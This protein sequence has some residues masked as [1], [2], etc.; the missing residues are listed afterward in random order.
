M[1]IRNKT[2]NEKREL[3]LNQST[4]NTN[5]CTHADDFVKAYANFTRNKEKN[6]VTVSVNQKTTK[7]LRDSGASV[8]CISKPFFEKAFLDNKPSINPC[9]IRSID[10][11]GGTHHASC[12]YMS[13][14]QCG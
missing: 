13:E 5:K 9:H 11:V 10:G 12:S 4:N 1:I 8:P 3:P 7:V 6:T 14:K 2:F